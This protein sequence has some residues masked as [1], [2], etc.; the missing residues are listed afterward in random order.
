[1]ENY[2]IKIGFYPILIA[3]T[4]SGVLDIFYFL[5]KTLAQKGHH[6]LG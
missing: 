2:A 1:M 6:R 4:L 3:I 5:I